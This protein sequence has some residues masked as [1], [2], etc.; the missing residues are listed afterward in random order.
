MFAGVAI[1]TFKLYGEAHDWPTPDLLHWESIAQRSR[2]HDWIIKPHRHSNLL[3]LLY[4]ESGVTRAQLDDQHLGIESPALLVIPPLTIHGFEFSPETQG[5]VLTLAS[6]L[7]QSIVTNLGDQAPRLLTA[8]AIE[9]AGVGKQRLDDLMTTIADEYRLQQDYRDAMLQMLTSQ[10]LVW[11]VRQIKAE[12]A[13]LDK[14][15]DKSQQYV[16]RFQQLIEQHY[17]KHQPLDF[18]AEQMQISTPHL[19]STCRKVVG[20][21]AL[22][23]VHERLLL[24]AKRNLV[25]SVLTVREISDSLGFS[26]PAYFTRFFKRLQKIS[27]QQFR[28]IGPN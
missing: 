21:S 14:G 22:T 8:N 13:S 16:L 12:S 18:Y 26:E 24:E 28:Q 1:P 17:R 20:M 7:L 4:I 5:H 23:L 6:P 25:Y 11:V 27:P 10:L 3:Q 2:Q 19:N 15:V 9:I